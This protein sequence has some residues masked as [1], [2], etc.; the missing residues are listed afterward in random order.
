MGNSWVIKGF[1]IQGACNINQFNLC[2]CALVARIKNSVINI[3]VRFRGIHCKTK[4][5]IRGALIGYERR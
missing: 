3:Q 2:F 4:K 5:G 1:F